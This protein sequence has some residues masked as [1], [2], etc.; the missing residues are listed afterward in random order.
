MSASAMTA[1]RTVRLQKAMWHTIVHSTG[2]VAAL[3]AF[4]FCMKYAFGLQKSVGGV[5]GRIVFG[6][7]RQP[8]EG[9]SVTLDQAFSGSNSND[10]DFDEV[11]PR[12]H[13]TTND[14]GT[15]HLTQVPVGTY[16]VSSYLS[17]H[18]VDQAIINVSEGGET[19]LTLTMTRTEPEFALAQHQRSFGTTDEI[20]I[21]VNGYT[22]GKVDSDHDEMSV[23]VY[24]T[25]V[26]EVMRDPA[27]AGALTLLSNYAY[28]GSSAQSMELPSDLIKPKGRPVATR[29]PDAT[30]RITTA[31]KE[32]FF[33]ERI[34]LGKRPPGMYLVE[35]THGKI[36]VST[37]VLVTDM[38]LVLKEDSKSTLAWAV[39]IKSGLP[40]AGAEI[41][42][43]RGLKTLKSVKTG[44][45][46]TA[47]TTKVKAGDDS[48]VRDLTVAVKGDDECL[49]RKPE[50]ERSESEGDYK[51]HVYTERPI[52]RPGQKIY[53][54]GILRRAVVPGSKYTIPTT[55]PVDV[56]VDDPG[57]ERIFKKRLTS[58]SFGSFTFDVDLTNESRTGVYTVVSRIG[59]TNNTSDFVVASYRKPEFEVKLAPKKPRYLVGESI[60]VEV[61]G[62]YYFG[63]PMAG[64]KVDYY[65]YS[66]ADYGAWDPDYDENDDSFGGR[67]ERGSYDYM[68]RSD[69]KGSVVLDKN[70]KATI[71]IKPQFKNRTESP[72]DRV[73]SITASVT[74]DSERNAESKIE[75]K[76][77]AGEYHLTVMPDGYLAFPGKPTTVQVR[78]VRDD[79]SPV[80]GLTIH[81]AANREI[82]KENE[83]TQ[84]PVSAADAV[85]DDAGIA[86]IPVTPNK[87]GSIQLEATAR[88][89]GNRVLRADNYLWCSGDVG[90][91][92]GTE[93]GDLTLLSDKRSYNPG[94]SARLLISSKNVGQLVLLTVEGDHLFKA[95]TLPISDK[96][97]VYNL[98]ILKDYGPN[99]FLNATYVKNKKF[100]TSQIGLRVSNAERTIKV[101]VTP[102]RPI[103]A[104]EKLASFHPRDKVGYSVLTTDVKGNPV[105]AEFSL[106]VVDES[107]YALRED[108]PKAIEK[109]FYPRRINEVR[110]SYSFEAEYLGDAD[111]AEPKIAARKK[112]PD[113]A[114][115]NPN[116]TTDATGKAHVMVDL[117]DNLTTWRATAVAQTRDTAFGYTSCKVMSTIDFSVRLEVPRYLTWRDRS[118]I[119]ATVHNNTAEAVTSY[120]KLVGTG[121][122][123]EGDATQKVQVAAK[124]SAHVEWK[125]ATQELEN[126]SFDVTAWTPKSAGPQLADRMQLTIPMRPHGRDEITRVGGEITSGSQAEVFRLDSNGDVKSAALTIRVDPSVAASLG[127]GLQ[128]LVGFP[129]GCTEQ[130]MSRF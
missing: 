69:R 71:K 94:D 10:N 19:P 45:D 70:G 51:V 121:V 65:A 29:E 43:Y 115:W 104:G 12:L 59:N 93:G 1:S 61:S 116:L 21:P 38:A 52:Y 16:N 48:K 36:A 130:T 89:T 126:A 63:S 87:A 77:S 122:A 53:F 85:T 80:K 83:S 91:D 8:A 114:Y 106:A 97:T 84:K 32:G 22:Q 58:S 75:V 100:A 73:I 62:E 41:R 129:Y 111:K 27:S 34:K 50:N 25:R 4:A 99:V 2:R 13:V 17:H 105:P 23:K 67:R 74:D 101:S 42:T 35:V 31:D 3:I 82:W 33:Y 107:I 11:Q 81:L 5:N 120:V 86:R 102:D 117:P 108:N 9:A 127:G 44:T 68:G 28:R 98:P 46:G 76:M 119:Q 110:T 96:A 124:G 15:F 49:V 60:E 30:H 103:K 56:E 54:K 47:M 118:V 66:R 64:A 39:G 125:I 37:W 40:V 90:E 92:M 7:T 109:V 123:V 6:D 55:S 95:L 24:K 79:G 113:T 112:F 26:S 57:G 18:K 20:E 72:Q 78:A 88:D 128:Y 14:D